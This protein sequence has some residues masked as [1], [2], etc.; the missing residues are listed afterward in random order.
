MI[1]PIKISGLILISFLI[2]PQYLH[3]ERKANDFEYAYRAFA[4]NLEEASICNKIFSGAVTPGA[5]FSPKGYQ[6]A[7]M[8]SECLFQLAQKTQNPFFCNDVKPKNTFFLNG[9]LYS[10]DNCVKKSKLGTRA[11]ISYS[12]N[13]TM[14]MQKM[15][16]TLDMWPEHIK[17]SYQEYLKSLTAEEAQNPSWVDYYLYLIYSKDIN[18]LNDFKNRINKLPTFT[19]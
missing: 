8:R 2:A 10:K 19:E 5:G 18:V 3:A 7:Y 13:T 17:H 11:Q 1:K 14:I 6:I 4:Y 9:S 15:G 12:F 16:Y